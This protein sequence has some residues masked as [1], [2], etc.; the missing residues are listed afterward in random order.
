MAGRLIW[1]EVGKRYYE[2]GVEQTALYVFSNGKYGTGV[3][4]TGITGITESPS[5]AEANDI[6]ADDIKYAS[7]ISAE[8]LG[9]TIEAYTYPDEWAFCDGSATP[10]KG[11]SIG[12][13][14]RST[15]GLAFKT[16]IG[17]DTA[18]EDDDAYKL[19]IMYGCTAA[20][21]EKAYATINDS[22]EAITFSWEISTIPV[23]IGTLNTTKEGEDT[24][25]YKPTSLIT[26]D[27]RHFTVDNK[28]KLQKIEDALYGSES[29]DP[30]LPMPAD[31]INYLTGVNEDLK[32]NP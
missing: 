5:G 31:I 21:S 25:T 24:K 23:A 17:N 9:A 14:S 11:L 13:Q 15:F 8:T 3:A 32:P 26:L 22:P 27:S 7:L 30:Y 19:H 16:K 2:T 6:Y 20:P 18:T 1:D 28:E 12:Q 10:V 29:T 4:W